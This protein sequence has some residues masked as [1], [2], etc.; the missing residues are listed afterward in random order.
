MTKLA[1]T[2]VKRGDVSGAL[3]ALELRLKTHPNDDEAARQLASIQLEFGDREQAIRNYE[4]LLARKE[5]DPVALNNL[6]WLYFE[7]KD[8]RAEATA[9]KAAAAAT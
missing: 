5:N 4:T 1:E 2:Q 7:V 9:R 8:A 3:N 6:A